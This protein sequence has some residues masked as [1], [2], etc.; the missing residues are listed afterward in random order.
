MYNRQC[1]GPTPVWG[2]FDLGL[3]R[4]CYGLRRY[5]TSVAPVVLRCVP[6]RLV[7]PRLRPDV[8][9]RS[10]ALDTAHAGIT[11]GSIGGFAVERRIMQEELR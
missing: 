1:Y 2:K 5:I 8:G 6:V 4:L 10:F 3:S 9:G 11:T 7:K